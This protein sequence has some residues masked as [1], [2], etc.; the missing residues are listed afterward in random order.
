MLDGVITINRRGCTC[1]DVLEGKLDVAGIQSRGLN[2]GEVVVAWWKKGV[3][4]GSMV[5]RSG[6]KGLLANCLASSVG[7]ARKC[8]KSDLFPTNMMTMLL[9]A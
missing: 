2:E 1:E 5:P 9:S 4:S 6:R 3:V 8:L 7:T